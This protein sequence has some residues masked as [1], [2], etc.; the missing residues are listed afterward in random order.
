[1]GFQLCD[2]VRKTAEQEQEGKN[3]GSKLLNTVKRWKPKKPSI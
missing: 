1:M 2:S 3:T